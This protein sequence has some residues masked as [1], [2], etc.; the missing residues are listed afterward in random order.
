M[1][2]SQDFAD[3]ASRTVAARFLPAPPPGIGHLPAPEQLP[4]AGS[5]RDAYSGAGV[6]AQDMIADVARRRQPHRGFC[7][8]VEPDA[9]TCRAA[10]GWPA[11]AECAGTGQ[12]C[13]MSLSLQNDS[14]LLESPRTGASTLTTFNNSFV[15]WVCAWIP[16]RV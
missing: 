3:C 1:E 6:W 8:R 15:C 13:F 9:P 16:I 7:V 4:S 5:P 14:E 12:L 2:T 10:P 11:E